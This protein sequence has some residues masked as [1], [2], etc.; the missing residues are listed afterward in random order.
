MFSGKCEIKNCSKPAKHI[1]SMPEYGV[2][3]MCA[4]C[5][6]ELYKS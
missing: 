2:I 1:G 6:N 4:D 5:Y 3:D